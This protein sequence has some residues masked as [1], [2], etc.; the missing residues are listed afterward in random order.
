MNPIEVEDE[1]QHYSGEKKDSLR[2][3]WLLNGV[4]SNG[5]FGALERTRPSE[6][7]GEFRS[8]VTPSGA[9]YGLLLS[10]IGNAQHR[11]LIPLYS[12][13]SQECFRTSSMESLNI[14][15]ENSALEGTGL[16]YECPISEF[17]FAPVERL[18]QSIDMEQMDQYIG[19]FSEVVERVGRPSF[20]PSLIAGTSVKNVD[21]SVVVPLQEISDVMGISVGEL[22]EA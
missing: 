17:D 20:L 7:A 1:L 8:M 15:Y 16:N 14:F 4:V 10:Q 18:L 19:E 9:A 5:F 3:R 12:R 22:M 6:I 2:G 11:F 21:L 13:K